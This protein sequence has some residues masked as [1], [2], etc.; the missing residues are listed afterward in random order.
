MKHTDN[1]LRTLKPIGQSLHVIINKRDA[2]AEG[3]NVDDKVKVTIE[4]EK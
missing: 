2:E 3:F 4:K 1:K